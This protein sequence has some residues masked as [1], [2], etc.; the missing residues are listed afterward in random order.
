MPAVKRMRIIFVFILAALFLF[1]NYL[2]ANIVLKVMA[3]N[4]SKEQVQK[5]PVKAYLPKETKPEDVLDKGDLEVAYDTQQGS[6]YVWGE[7]ELKPG[8][9]IE[10]DIEIRDIWAVP[11]NEIETLRL[12][13][14]KL[15]DMLKNTEFSERVA[16]L[17]NSIESKLNQIIENQRTT[18]A[19]PEQHISEFRDNQRIL[20][21]VKA[22]LAL[23]RSLL[24]QAKPMPTV[25][26]WRLIIAII[27]FLGILAASFF[28]VWQ[29][30]ARVI[31]E[32]T[33][34]NAGK[35]EEEYFSE[36]K[37]S[38]HKSEEEKGLEPG[39]I[40]KMLDEENPEEKA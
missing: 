23:A 2:E 37:P 15:A 18:P 6:Y 31:T 38:A 28:F 21:S 10:R 11:S 26:V 12:E 33:F 36:T 24:S 27:I 13:S 14:G 16:F 8:E 39:D 9:V 30:Q 4:P 22:D 32:D 1:S 5:V 19:N 40:K 3:I 35:K 20:E 17:K 7:F 34:V 25:I 29:K